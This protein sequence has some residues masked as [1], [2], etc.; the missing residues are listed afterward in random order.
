MYQIDQTETFRAWLD[1]L[2]DPK[3]KGRILARLTA[4]MQGN[5]GDCRSVGRG[6]FEMR[7]HV[8]PGYRVYFTRTGSTVY[9]LLCGGDKDTQAKDIKK[10]QELAEAFKGS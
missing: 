3:G 9:L 1:S 8:G 6:V 4:A 5:F 10:A 2:R 7:I